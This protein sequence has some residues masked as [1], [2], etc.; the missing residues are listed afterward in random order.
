MLLNVN[1]LKTVDASAIQPLEQRL[2]QGP[3]GKD[4][5]EDDTLAGYKHSRSLAQSCL[6]CEASGPDLEL[7]MRS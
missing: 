1:D 4:D 3:D 6:Q 7:Y 2:N 5:D